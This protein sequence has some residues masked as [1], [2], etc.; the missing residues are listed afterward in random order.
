[1]SS[2]ESRYDV[3]RANEIEQPVEEDE[4]SYAVDYDESDDYSG[5]EYD[6]YPDDDTAYDESEDEYNAADDDFA[7]QMKRIVQYVD[8]ATGEASVSDDDADFDDDD[9]EYEFDDDEFSDGS[10]DDDDVSVGRKPIPDI[11]AKTD[12]RESQFG[13]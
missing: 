4:E 2:P 12:T 10:E 3:I 13:E 1:M 6:D 7:V 8:E 5:E 11:D 9:Y